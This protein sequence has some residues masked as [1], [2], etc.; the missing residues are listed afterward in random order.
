MILHLP[1]HDSV[2]RMSFPFPG[3]SMPLRILAVIGLA[4]ASFWLIRMLYRREL[5][6]TS[7]LTARLIFGIRLALL[8]ILALLLISDPTLARTQNEVVP[9]RVL[10][11]VDLSDS[12]RVTDPNRPVSEKLKLALAMKMVT[13]LA[14]DNELEDWIANAGHPRFSSDAEHQRYEKVMARVDSTPRIE[15]CRRLLAILVEPLREKFSVELVGFG[16]D[17]VSLPVDAARQEKAL[18]SHSPTEGRP[19]VCTDL[20]LPLNLASDMSGSDTGTGPKLLG[21]VL[22]TDGR[23]NWGGLPLP[24]AF[25]LGARGIPVHSI[26]LSAR[27]SPADIAIVS[28]RAAAATVFKGSTVPVDVAIRV[29]GWPAGPVPVTL[30]LPDP[31]K[32][33]LVETIQ[34]NGSDTTYH[35]CFKVKCEEPGPQRFTVKVDTGPKDRFPENNRRGARVNV[36][37]D[38]ARVLLIDGEARWE[39]HYLHT[40]LGRDPNMDMQSIVFRQPRIG[41]V[42]EEELKASGVPART[43][44]EEPDALTSYDVIVLGDIE[45]SQMSLESRAKLENYVAESGGT[46]VLSVGK[47]AMPL[48]YMSFESEPLRRLLPLRELNVFES[49]DGFP[50]TLTPAG[51]RSWFLTLEDSSTASHATWEKFPLHYWSVAGELKDGAEALATA[52]NGKVVFARQNFGFGRVLYLGIDS[53]WRWRFKTGDFFHHRF[54]GQIAQWAASDR[55]LPVSNASG[56]IRFGPREPVYNGGQDVEVVVRASVAAKALPAGARKAARLVKLPTVIGSTETAVGLF[57]MSA[58]EGRPRDLQCRIPNLTSGRYA[59]ELDIPEWAD[60]LI[61]PPGPDGRSEKLRAYFEVA[62]QDNEEL[63]DLSANW[64]LLTEL[65]DAS[66]GEVVTPDNSKK[67]LELLSKQTAVRHVTLERPLRNSWAMLLLF[68]LLLAAEWILRKWIGL[69]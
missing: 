67:I 24:K 66:K 58:P 48:A 7:R 53:T 50:L 32:T 11:A 35:L 39:F 37:K 22:L 60:E 44:P 29:T 62:P 55:L 69:P 25:E 59:V 65:A 17:I 18:A 5:N 52:P 63:I 68:L 21:V 14:S 45:P 10:I 46:L 2:L 16:P 49:I 8:G 28:A 23:H 36:V 31:T 1:M 47:R 64:T 56:T 61:G 57:P 41:K 6:H 51:E 54:W 12:M 33:P 15:L 38:R 3:F 30:A 40:C 19:I 9:G 27:E 20:K 26:A 34:H 4:A 42:R 43:L 13:D